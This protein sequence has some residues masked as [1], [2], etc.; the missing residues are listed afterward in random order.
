MDTNTI[1]RPHELSFKVP[2][3]LATSINDLIDALERE[4]S[5]ID[6][7][8]DD[9]EQSARMVNEENDAWIRKYYA[10]YGWMNSTR[11]Y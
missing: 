4:D 7:Y 10:R 3:P 6:M 9:V 1:L 11:S 8:L 2:A 5:Q